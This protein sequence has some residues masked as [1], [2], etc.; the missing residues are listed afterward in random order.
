MRIQIRMQV[1]Y[2]VF[3][4]YHNDWIDALKYLC[5]YV[6]GYKHITIRAKSENET[7]T[8]LITVSLD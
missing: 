4:T 3:M 8:T 1:G 2:T 5:M 6:R 7:A